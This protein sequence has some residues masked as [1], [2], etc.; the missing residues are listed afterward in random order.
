MLA[1]GTR[2][3]QVELKLVSLVWMHLKQQSYDRVSVF[4][5]GF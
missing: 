2:Q 5:H 4:S 1:F 3:I